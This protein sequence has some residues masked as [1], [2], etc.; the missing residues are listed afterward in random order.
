MKEI[1]DLITTI[2]SFITPSNL[3]IIS[4]GSIGGII[5]GCLPGLTSTMGIALL[6]GITYGMD[7]EKALLVL[8]GIYVGGTY[9]GSISAVLI[10]IPGTGSAAATVL[11]GNKLA[12]KGEGRTA[13]SLAT[14]ASFVGTIFGM[15]CLAVFAP[16]LQSLAFKF[17][18]V[19]YALLAVFGVSICG[20]LTAGGT[21]IKGWISG[22][23]GL[24]LACVGYEGIY[25]Y[26]RFTYGVVGLASG[27]AIVPA[28]IG[29]FGIP[30]VLEEL[31]N[32]YKKEKIVEIKKGKNDVN[33]FSM[34]KKHL[35]L[36]LT[37]GVIGTFVGAVPG[38][39]E[40]IAAWLSYDTAKKASKNPEEFGKGS[41]EGVIAAETANNAAIGGAMI[42]LLSLAIPGSAPTAV[43]LGALMLH[44]I[45]PGPMLGIDNPHFVVEM[46]AMLILAA[47]CMRVFGYLICQI[48]PKILSVPAFILMPI[49]TAL[50]VIGSYAINLS[51][52]DLY[53]MLIL[54]VLGYFLSVMNY[55]AAPAVLGLILGGMADTNLRR[56]L[57]SSGGS[58]LP[59]VTRPVAIVID[60]MILFSLFGQ[61]KFIKNMVSKVL[62]IFSR[63]GEEK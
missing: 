7:P 37:S 8:L 52:F 47:I 61:T 26:P 9:G 3:L 35:R 15:I 5:F 63:K 57:M 48:A 43:L 50:S 36:I 49:I 28:L 6:T 16:A 46:C 45:R 51:K 24:A 17:T 30:S 55:P 42:P 23:L 29:F 41:Y 58:L 39:G 19:E 1:I 13:L 59:F 21:P 53:S 33:V 31:S 22:F 2:I 10:G 32:V 4:L 25:S 20:T 62:Q 34:L 12:Q 54:G 60:L 14:L 18:S 56:A 44:G 27:I 40:D 38:V 11:D